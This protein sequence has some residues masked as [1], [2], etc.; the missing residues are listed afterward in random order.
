MWNSRESLGSDIIGP[1]WIKFY[2]EKVKD[3]DG[4]EN[5]IFFIRNFFPSSFFLS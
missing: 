1:L 4:P 3:D 2:D 5:Y